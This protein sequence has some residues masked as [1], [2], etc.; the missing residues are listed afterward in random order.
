MA[1]LPMPLY[2]AH[3]RGAASAIHAAD[4]R[5]LAMVTHQPGDSVALAETMAMAPEALQT[6][7]NLVAAICCLDADYCAQHQVAPPPDGSQLSEALSDA[8]ACIR[9]ARD[10]GVPLHPEIAL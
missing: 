2:C 5:L 1:S 4:G 8:I 6:L 3:A 7:A 10:L 9:T